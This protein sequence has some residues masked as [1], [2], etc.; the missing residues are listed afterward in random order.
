MKIYHNFLASVSPKFPDAKNSRYTVNVSLPALLHLLPSVFQVPKLSELV[1]RIERKGTKLSVKKSKSRSSAKEDKLP[2]TASMIAITH[3][4]AHKGRGD[5][6]IHT[7]DGVWI[8]NEDIEELTLYNENVDIIASDDENNKRLVRISRSG[9]VTTLCNTGELEPWG[10]C[11]NDKQ[12]I[13]VGVQAGYEKQSIKLAVYSPDGSALLHEIEKDKSGKTLFTTTIY[14][15]KQ[16]GNGDYVVADCARIVCVSGE[17]EYRWKYQVKQTGIL[18]PRVYG[19]VCDRYDNI[20]ITECNND[21]ISLL[22]SEGKLITTLMTR[23]DG[24]SDPWSLA[25][26]K[27]GHLWIGQSGLVKVIYT[28]DEQERCK[29]S[30]VTGNC[31]CGL[32]WVGQMKM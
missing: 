27:Q 8:N 17:G 7:N 13:V 18:T 12:Q 30:V 22:D 11:I 15:V 2:F 10:F 4:N 32:L 28:E 6:I 9:A 16:N 20:I 26:N 23:E 3:A 25:I 21:K 29:D 24:V 14:Q 1:G 19:M 5:S 31:E